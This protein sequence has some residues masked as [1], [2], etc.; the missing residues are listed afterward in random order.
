MCA[1]A[2]GI[3]GLVCVGLRPYNGRQKSYVNL[4]SAS[5]RV[6]PS[7]G[8]PVLPLSGSRVCASNESPELI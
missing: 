4:P 5:I 3:G 7:R 2:G 1:R 8:L 6:L